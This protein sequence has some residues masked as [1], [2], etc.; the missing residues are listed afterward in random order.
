MPSLEVVSL[1]HTVTVIKECLEK[2][3]QY[4]PEYNDCISSMDSC[5]LVSDDERANLDFVIHYRH[6]LKG[7]TAH[8]IH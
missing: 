8:Y 1:K 2:K 6:S 5:H 7:C 4:F 3:N